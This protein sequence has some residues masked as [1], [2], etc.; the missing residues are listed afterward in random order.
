VSHI[1]YFSLSQLIYPSIYEGLVQCSVAQPSWCHV[2]LIG[3]E[4]S[5]I[6]RSHLKILV[7]SM[8]TWR[9]FHP[10]DLKIL[11]ASVKILSPPYKI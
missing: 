6:S 10:K 1:Y 3:E 4:I 7:A 11:L 5:Q 2:P 9:K 8:I